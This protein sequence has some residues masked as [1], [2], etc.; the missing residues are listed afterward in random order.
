V[1][2]AAGD[3]VGG[4]ADLGAAGLG[5]NEGALE[6]WMRCAYPPYGLRGIGYHSLDLERVD[7]VLLRIQ[8]GD[9]TNTIGRVSDIDIPAH[10][11]VAEDGSLRELDEQDVILLVIDNLHGLS[12]S[13]QLTITKV[14]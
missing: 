1:A 6:W 13:F 2:D 11:L 12:R 8:D 9:L 4:A 14:F 5:T 3:S 10:R 7:P